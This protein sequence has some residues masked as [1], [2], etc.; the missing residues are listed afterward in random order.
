MQKKGIPSVTCWGTGSPRRELLYVEDLAEAVI[1]VLENIS[2]DNESLFDKNSNYLGI[3]NVGIGTDTPINKLADL[4]AA[5]L[6]YKGE[7]VWDLSKP[8]GTPRKLLD[9]KKL[10]NLGWQARTDFQIGIKKTI[11]DYIENLRNNS[12]RQK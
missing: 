7:I 11:E 2:S 3:L 10:T 5:E 12:L 4:V 9:T 1:F 8:D 6:D